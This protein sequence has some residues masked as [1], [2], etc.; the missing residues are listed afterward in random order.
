MRSWFRIFWDTLKVFVLFIGCTVLF[1][2]ALMWV[3]QEY[4]S[5]HRY[6]KPKGHAV[7]V[8]QQTSDH[9]P[10]DWLDRLELFYQFGE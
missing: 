10:Y 4:A 5:Y 7:E 8:S 2:Y 6:D 1:Y 3:N 9:H